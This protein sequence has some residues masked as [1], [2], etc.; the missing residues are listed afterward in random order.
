MIFPHPVRAVIFDMDG[1]LL[2]TERLYLIAIRDAC[3]GMG[4]DAPEAFFQQMLG[5]P[6]SFCYEIMSERF[7]VRFARDDFDPPFEARFAELVANGVPVK[8]G[9]RELI[10][11]LEARAVPLAVA[12]STGREKAE[13]HL[14]RAGLLSSFPVLVTR[15]RVTQGKPAPESFLKA[16]AEL[17]VAPQHC[18]AL[19]DSPTGVRAAASS[20][21]MTIMV[22]DVVAATQAERSLC[23]AVVD[24]MFDVLDFLL[25]ARTAEPVSQR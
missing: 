21:A 14:E 25:A 9:V 3:A 18:L 5:R 7:G 10:S 19:E 23:L 22:P 8:P 4:L 11:H 6:W 2:D 24:D 12:T 1:T 17:G 16:A 15:D 20:G 13:R